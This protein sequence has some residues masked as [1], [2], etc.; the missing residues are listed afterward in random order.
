MADF[1]A[2]K[3]AIQ[4][5]I[6]QNGNEEI[7]GTILQEVMLAVVSTLGDGAIG[8]LVTALSTEVTNRQNADGTLQTNI[9]NEA[10]ARGNADTALSN[11]LGSTITAE[12]TAADQIGAESEARAAAD[13]ALQGLIDGITDN[14]ENGYVYAGIATPSSTPA[15]GKVFYLAL[16]AGT[17]TNFGSTVVSQ[18]INILKYNGSAWSLDVMVALDNAPTPSSNNLVKSGG[19]F[20]KVMTDSSAFDISAH[21]ASGGTLATYADLSAALTALNTLSASYKRGGMSIK[22]VQSS[23]NKYVQWRLMANSFSTIVSDWQGVDE[24]PTAGSDNLVKSEGIMKR[25]LQF[26]GNVT[27]L[28]GYAYTTTSATPIMVATVDYRGFH[29]ENLK[30][31][32]KFII[33]V[34]GGGSLRGWVTTDATNNI[35]RRSDSSINTLSN[36]YILTLE[37]NETQI[38]GNT[39]P[40]KVD[41]SFVCP[42]DYWQI[43][44]ELKT[45]DLNLQNN[46]EKNEYDISLILSDL[47]IAIA[48]LL[49]NAINPGN[50][51]EGLPQPSSAG[52]G[53]GAYKFDIEKYQGKKVKINNVLFSNVGWCL[54]FSGEQQPS[55]YISGT[56]FAIENEQGLTI[57]ISNNAKYLIVNY[58]IKEDAYCEYTPD[59]N[60]YLVGIGDSITNG[61]GA[62]RVALSYFWKLRT[63]LINQNIV[64]N[65]YNFN[66]P[67]NTSSGIASFCSAYPLYVTSDI[68]IP[69][70]TTPIQI[71]LNIGIANPDNNV[72]AGVNPCFIG[73]I[74]G[75]ISY[76]GSDFYFTRAN[77]GTQKF[78]SA[79]TPIITYGGKMTLNGNILTI[80]VGTND[81][82]NQYSDNEEKL[83]KNI[84]NLSRLSKNGK[85]IIILPYV[86]ST[87]NTFRDAMF[88]EFG[89]K[90]VDLYQYFSTNAVIDAVEQ[91]LLPSGSLQTDWATLLLSDGTHP[92]DIGHELI[93]QQIYNRIIELGF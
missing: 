60:E 63:A 30:A 58:F 78:V 29:I 79:N 47:G 8:D 76:D 22:F 45:K 10:T 62:S 15:T 39:D 87:T 82:I 35:I 88:S 86:R 72:A 25:I 53:I 24:E 92:N 84:I 20:D 61:S 2:L 74:E 38:Y 40:T 36:P 21:F 34:K 16:T 13:T 90:C 46:I 52:L 55:T 89:Q 69:A 77:A 12:N 37:G 32:D 50:G 42:I 17:Y 71:G 85:F 91:G 44:N 9:N 41:E 81:N 27:F 54:Q 57:Q 64:G 66:S 33:A 51:N 56:K 80:F 73:G 14:I 70:T 65:A 26:S 1:T 67:G 11:R 6:K 19:V 68:S 31:G 23:D 43:I 18:G 7:T 83:I 48:G 28:E 3:T 59:L 49:N 4:N 93:Y 5:A 75:T